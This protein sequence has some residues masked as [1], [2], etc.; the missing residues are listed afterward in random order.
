MFFYRNVKSHSVTNA[1]ESNSGPVRIDLEQGSVAFE[2]DLHPHIFCWYGVI[3]MAVTDLSQVTYFPG[4]NIHDLIA[5]AR[6]LHQR[7][8]FTLIK[9]QFMHFPGCTVNPFV[10]DFFIPYFEFKNQLIIITSSK[11]L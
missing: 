9:Y 1:V 2:S 10:A 5:F 7:I 8:F 6:Q 3:I 11:I 4:G